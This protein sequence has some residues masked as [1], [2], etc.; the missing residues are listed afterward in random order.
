M[1]KVENE[2]PDKQTKWQFLSQKFKHT[3]KLLL[4]KRVK[5]RKNNND[6]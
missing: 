6:N 2:E 3:S 1:H 5:S 4:E